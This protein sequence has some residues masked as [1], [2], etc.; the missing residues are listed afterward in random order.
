MKILGLVVEYNPFHYG[1]LYQ[2]ERAKE[3]VKPSATI[4]VM[5]GNFTQRGEPALVD[6][7]ARAEMAVTAG[8]DLVLEL[9]VMWA[10]QSAPGFAT[11]ALHLLTLAGATDICFG[12]ELGQIDTLEAV[13]D[14]LLEEPFLYRQTLHKALKLGHSFATAQGLALQA[15]CPQTDPA[16]CKQPNNTLAI[17][18]LIAI[19]KFGLPIKAH[20]IRRIGSYH[21]LLPTETMLSATAIRQ[22]VLSGHTA[23]GMPKAAA[24]ILQQRIDAGQGP[25]NWQQLAPYLFYH[26]RS[27]TQIAEHQWPEAGEGLGERLWLAARQTNDWEKLLR[28]VKTR[29]FPLTRLQRLCTY[30]LLGLTPTQIEKVDITQPPPYLRVLALNTASLTIRKLL[31]TSQLPVIYS[32]AD[33]APTDTR[34]VECL[35]QD[36]K[37]TD[38]Y[39]LAWQRGSQSGLDFTHR[40]VTR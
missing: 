22:Q 28:S 4:A 18:Y 23:Q 39:T 9:P 13:S 38:I 10:T 6:K 14:I 29:R 21:S 11:G 25:V 26:L 30:V 20:T 31:K 32:A 27:Q 15:A 5:S 8:I 19:K 37:A 17:E 12:S 1:H 33:V 7:W 2:L 24:S 34:L 40:L 36:I 35:Q 3:L 16:L